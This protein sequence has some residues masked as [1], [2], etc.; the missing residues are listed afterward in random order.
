MK[1]LLLRLADL[2]AQLSDNPSLVTSDMSVIPPYTNDELSQF[3]EVVHVRLS[4]ALREFYQ[5]I[6]G[7][8]LQWRIKEGCIPLEDPEDADYLSGSIQLLDPYIMIMGPKGDRWKDVFWFENLSSPDQAL[9][10][11]LVAFDFASSEFGCGFQIQ[12]GVIDETLFL[13]SSSNGVSRWNL[14]FYEY[15]KALCETRGYLY[16]QTLISRGKHDEDRQRMLR[17][18]SLLFPDFKSSALPSPPELGN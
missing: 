5:T 7:L 18:L 14:K 2:P 8:R 12:E 16:W 4:S 15:L 10:G 13:Y 3:E 9:V 6:G 1:D 11:S 17:Y